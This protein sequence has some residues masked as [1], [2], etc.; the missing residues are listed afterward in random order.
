MAELSHIKGT[1][2]TGIPVI[3]AIG[4]GLSVVDGVISATGSGGGSTRFPFSYGDASPATVQSVVG[5]VATA[6]IIITTPFNGAGAALSLGDAGNP[7]RLIT[8]S[9]ILPSI[10]SEWV[11]NP[12]ELYTVSTPIILTITPGSG[13]SQGS[14]YVIL[15]VV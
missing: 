2:P 6:T 9:Q 1:D 5:L 3:A 4:T 12:G 14:G 7:Q 15:E 11:T 8:T 13:A 10:A